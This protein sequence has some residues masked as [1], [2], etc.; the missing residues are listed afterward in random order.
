MDNLL[1][2][3]QVLDPLF[4]IGGYTLSGGLETYTQKGLV[5]DRETLAAYLSAQ[6]Y[7]LPYGDLGVAAKA[8]L[9]GDFVCLDGLCAA[10]KTPVEIREG[11]E[12]LCAH[13]LKAQSVLR[14]FPLLD[15]YRG[16]IADGRC[17][18]HYPVAVGLFIKSIEADI[19][20]ALELYCYSILSAAANHTVK[21]VPLRQMDGQLSISAIMKRVPTAA[22][23][24][25][26]V[27]MDELGV[28]GCGFDLRAMQHET[29]PGRLYI[30]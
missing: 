16:T 21:L 26:T 6:L 17:D 9:G 18:G 20:T 12:K 10:M 23:K 25:K 19:Q 4:P 14:D 28:S 24:A 27:S 13:F 15:E 30:S 7:L 22:Q 8:A 29:L 2:L 5:R 11:S 3:I 1:P